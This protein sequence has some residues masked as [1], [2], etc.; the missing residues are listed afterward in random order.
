MR[1]ILIVSLLALSASSTLAVAQSPGAATAPAAST[2][3]TAEQA[4]D[5]LQ[6]LD[7]PRRR[8]QIEQ[9]LR[10]IAAAGAVSTEPRPAG[11]APTLS[12]PG[13]TATVSATISPNGLVS[14]VI[15]QGAFLAVQT[16]LSLR[17]S[18]A[19]LLDI[20]SVRL[21][22]NRL[23]KS[24]L[25][26][27]A[28][29]SLLWT[30]CIALLPALLLAWFAQRALR[31]I[32][33]PAV[34]HTAPAGVAIAD[35][36][37]RQQHATLHI[38]LLA[39]LPR[40]ALRLLLNLL[41]L[42]VFAAAASLMMSILSA[43]GKPPDRAADSLIEIY[44][45]SRT[46]VIISGFLFQSGQ[47]GLRLLRVSDESAAFTQR[48][49]VRIVSVVAF[50]SAL[51]ATAFALGLNEE[52]YLA[53]MK[54]VALVA[55]VMLSIWI[56]QCREPVAARVRRAFAANPSLVIFGDAL[57]DSWAFV[58][59]FIVMALW[60]VWALDVRS[61]YRALEH[62]GGIT[63]AIL[64]VARLVSILAFGA[65]AKLFQVEE[66]HAGRS[67]VHQHA[68]RYY[69]YL[70][71]L[72][73]W[74]ITA[75][76]A[77]LMLQV[78]GANVRVVFRGG[79]VVHRLTSALLSIAVAAIIALFVWEWINVSVERQLNRWTKENELARAARLRTLQPMLRAALLLAIAP[80]V[81]LVALSD[82][83]VSIAPLLAGASIFGVALGFGSQKFVQD[84]ITG[85][86]LLIDNSIQVGDWVTLA[87]VSGTVE[88]LSIRTVRLRA[89][90]GSLYT[91][92]F[93]SVSTV[94]NT[95]RGLG[96]VLIKVCIAFGQ[97]IDPAI[98]TLKEIGAGLREDKNFKDGIL[99]DFTFWGVDEI[100]GAAVT[101]SG[102]M[103]CLDSARWSVQRE[104]N[105]RILDQFRARGI[106]IANPHR[107]VM[108]SSNDV[109][110]NPE[111]VAAAGAQDTLPAAAANPQSSRSPASTSNA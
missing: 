24:P 8:A 58:A 32:A 5:A 68:Y 95:N 81:L 74:T 104:F 19:A 17:R 59:V 10:A 46:V 48:W 108:V 28:L 83:G 82:L 100:D 33:V 13:S 94:N 9:T 71:R 15:H 88:H 79:T 20:A 31:P 39:R 30:L 25:E 43:A 72:L 57:A 55:H 7:D 62:V 47:S 93:S 37:D 4:R 44:V 40:A 50:G 99:T 41:P 90:D 56:L 91:V 36:T 77:L 38:S 21:W 103:K 22:W 98:A 12:A 86:F 106:Q 63:I 80:V 29:V 73:G 69:P 92:P 3:L 26:R 110:A 27:A 87:G 89:S 102:Q 96:I 11:P 52:A 34:P 6:I 109:P 16:G 66:E 78:W 105:R 2:T 1:Q 75:V 45:V 101:L 51:A 54:V 85:I 60:S 64:V 70:R 107:T 97:D 61:G 49:V 84:V 14:Q 76:T 111:A 35:E 18:V 65:V 53:L 23:L 67:L 42:V